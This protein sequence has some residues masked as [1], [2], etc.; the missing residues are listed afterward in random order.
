M[1]FTKKENASSGEMTIPV[2]ERGKLVAT[3]MDGSESSIVRFPIAYINPVMRF[4][5]V[6]LSNG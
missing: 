1:I 5:A 4:L 3:S 6:Y 2:C